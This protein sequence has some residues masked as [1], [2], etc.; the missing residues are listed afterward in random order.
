VHELVL[1]TQY[2]ND[3][4]FLA[5]GLVALRHWRRRQD[6]AAAWVA[7]TF[8]SL[9]FVVAIGALLPTDV[10][11]GD[12]LI[13]AVKLLVVVLVLFPYLLYRFAATFE[14]AKPGLD[15]WAGAV[16]LVV[17]LAGL[18]LPDLPGPG[19]PRPAWFWAF[20]ALLLVQ[21][22]SLSV[23][24][25]F[26]LWRGGRG[27]PTM[28]RRRMRVLCLASVI[29]NVALVVAASAPPGDNESAATLV[30]NVMATA[31]AVL[32]F[33]GFAPP[34][35]VR[36]AWRRPEEQAM[37]AAQLRLMAATTGG[38]VVD[39]LLPSMTKML[40][41]Q[42]AALVDTEGSVVGS[43]GTVPDVVVDP[44]EGG[45]GPVRLEMQCGRLLI[46]TSPHTPFFGREELGLLSSFGVVADLAMARC[47]LLQRQRES[48][49]DLEQ[50]NVRLQREIRER[51]LAAERLTQSEQRLE[52][53]QQIAHIGG[54]QWEIEPNQ[55]TWSD[56]LYR[57][58]GLEPRSFAPTF[59]SF[60]ERVPAE[61]GD[62][63]VAAI[64]QAE[65][66]HQPFSFDH[67]V[68]R[69]D[70]DIRVVHV[71]GKVVTGPDGRPVRMTGTA[72]DVTERKA[73][74]DALVAA[75]DGERQARMAF[76]RT[77]GE[78]ESFVYSVSH[79][80]K[81]PM[82]SLLGYLDYL[83][84]VFGS[85]LPEE[86]HR[87]L[88]RMTASGS[89]LQA[90]IQDLLELSR[91]GR[92]ATEREPVDLAHVLAD[93]RGEVMAAH[94]ATSIEVGPLPV[95]D[96]NPLRIRQLL[97]NLVGNAVD[98]GGRPD[99]HVRISSE[100]A[101]DGS[102]VV[103]VSDD[104]PGIPEAYREKVFGVFER[105]SAREGPESGTGIGLA[106]CKK[107]MESVGGAIWVDAAESGATF[108]ASFPQAMVGRVPSA[109]SSKVGA[110]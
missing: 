98:H 11:S 48:A 107:I 3:L 2:L 109:A 76:E 19:E 33:S 108:C 30:T 81:S 83:K 57:I 34:G 94:P 93:I 84:L 92:S 100:V 91:V 6:E 63:V 68:V 36:L 89:Y 9:G 45:A 26:R 66:D 53:A 5:L 82:I 15:R 90:L 60:V 44:G 28:T 80:L 41:G 8:M 50:T 24:V 31:C 42:G 23:V 17:V 59:A 21:W 88:D 46:W 86:A 4:L 43:Y 78:L 51:T 39:Q 54:W 99:V 13:W 37:Q 75:Y 67:H 102:V 32:F 49:A 55:V 64:R 61:D 7:A 79:D 110:H 22:T 69:P 1:G 14:P 77:N 20:V 10:D 25:A 47:D 106:I 12:P 35:F 103:S 56:E 70:G 97:T 58:Y 85:A 73:I 62:R 38:E 18:A 52:E 101:A 96:M 74:E 105:L 71:Q 104:G 72:Q 29:L 65:G 27:Q 87:Y 16:T 95:L 40:G